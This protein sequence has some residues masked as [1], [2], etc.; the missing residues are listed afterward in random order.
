[1]PPLLM[2]GHRFRRLLR[3]LAV[4]QLIATQ[5]YH[6]V[7]QDLR[8]TLFPRNCQM[9]QNTVSSCFLFL[10]VLFPL[11]FVQLRYSRL[12]RATMRWNH[13][14]SIHR[15]I[16]QRLSQNPKDNQIRTL[17]ILS[18]T[19]VT[20]HSTISVL[21]CSISVLLF[22]LCLFPCLLLFAFCTRDPLCICLLRNSLL[23][24]FFHLRSTCL[25]IYSILYLVLMLSQ[26][27]V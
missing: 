26:S 13:M 2:E 4:L 6:R 12:I 15:Q 22:L 9:I 20:H 11:P 10:I 21:K 1:M 3:E 24:S 27:L 7:A 19:Y 14:K 18:T 5:T 23:R 25:S 17:L 8:R 16:L